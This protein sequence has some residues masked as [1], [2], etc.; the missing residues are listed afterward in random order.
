MVPDHRHDMLPVAFCYEITRLDPT[1]AEPHLVCKLVDLRRH[2]LEQLWMSSLSSILR[3][4]IAQKHKLSPLLIKLS[5]L[6]HIACV[7]RPP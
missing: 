7:S 3:F 5:Q 2:K 6:R 4:L 1:I